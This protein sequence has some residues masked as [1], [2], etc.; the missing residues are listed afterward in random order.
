MLA[1]DSRTG[2]GILFKDGLIEGRHP[3]EPGMVPEYS[4]RVGSSYDGESAASQ[5]SLICGL[6]LRVYLRAQ[7]VPRWTA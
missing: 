6:A 4:G 2:F 7:D 3:E 5:Q 1:K